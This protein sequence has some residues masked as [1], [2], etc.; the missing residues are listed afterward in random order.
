[1]TW[2]RIN[3]D[4]AGRAYSDAAWNARVPESVVDPRDRRL[5]NE[6]NRRFD[7]WFHRV[8]A[9]VSG[10]LIEVGCAGSAWLPYFAREHGLTVTGLDYSPR[11]CEQAEAVLATA[12]VAG[13]VV[14]ADLFAPPAAQVGRFDVVF[15]FG[16]VEHFTD[17]TACIRAL[18]ALVA[19]GG[20][21]ITVVPNMNGTTGWLQKMVDRAV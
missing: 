20:R 5:D 10:R 15:S 13:E 19:P 3:E 18:A 6:V 7:A 16:V 21:L 4:K 1:M 17:T 2:M 14:C 12:G 8:L 11:G 9:G